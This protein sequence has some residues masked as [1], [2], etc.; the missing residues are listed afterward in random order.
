M[1]DHATLLAA[2][3]FAAHK[4]RAQRRKDAD[5]SPY[6]NHPLALAHVLATEGRVKDL[7]T[8]IAAVLHDT[9]EDTETTYGE[10]VDHFGKKV[11][12][13]VMEVTDD[14]SLAKADRKRAQIEHAPHMSK[15]AALVKL[16][17]KTCNLRDMAHAPPADWPLKRK[18]E[19]FNWAKSVVDGLPRVN[20]RMLKAFDAAFAARP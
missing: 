18:H 2:I 1:N 10:L 20:K 11:A 3:S 16:A 17:D 7:K 15:R 13:V 6:I 12:D 5:A 8:L 19:Y 9:V 14:K 4:H